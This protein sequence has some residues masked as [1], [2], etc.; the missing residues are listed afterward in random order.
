MISKDEII[1]ILSKY[2]MD[3][4]YQAPYLYEEEGRFGI[5]YSFNHAFY[6][7]LER[8]HWFH[9]VIEAED[10]IYQLWWYKKYRSQFMVSI[11]LEDYE[12]MCPQVF[13]EMNEKELS[14]QDMKNL[15]LDPDEMPKEKKKQNIYRRLL[16]TCRILVAIIE[17]KVK[18]QNDTYGNVKELD[19]EFQRQENEFYQLYNR[20]TKENLALHQILDTVIDKV[21]MDSEIQAL[22]ER[23]DY[24]SQHTS[25][26]DMK[27]FIDSLWDTL[28]SMESEKGYLQN[29][30]LL[31]KLPIDLEDVRKKKEYMES[32]FNKKKSLFSKK[33]H[34]KE[35]LTKIDE[36]SETKK[37]ISMK[38]FIDNEVK[39]LEEK[40][41]II[42]E[43]DYS[44]LG[45]Y[46]NEFDNL[47][48]AAPFELQDKPVEKVYT[49][50]ELLKTYREIYQSLTSEEQRN[51]AIYH[52]FMQPICDAILRQMLEQKMMEEILLRV[53][54]DFEQD[55]TQAMN[56][57]TDSENVFL[58]IQKM[59]SLSL[60]NVNTFL[61]SLYDVCENLLKI[62]AFHL[63][64]IS[65]FFGKSMKNDVIDVYHASL[66][67]VSAPVQ[68]KGSFEVHDI[69]KV[70]SYVSVLFLPYFY[71]IKDSFFH[72]NTIEEIKDRED[73]LIFLKKYQ[74]NF[75]NSDIIKVSRFHAS[76]KFEGPCKIMFGMK[77]LRKEYY[78][79][80]DIIK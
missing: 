43:M 6:G 73:V 29:K 5:L 75:N 4:K 40:Y 53:R 23:I 39:R 45:D 18:V 25:F 10:F 31:F 80:I 33:E 60:K 71:D 36:E 32:V 17:E 51:L 46:L 13:F 62:K 50:D 49:H 24:L 63:N 11:H 55:I 3:S 1:T 27:K 64:G 2:G 44:T 76:E 67:N 30:Y 12:S 28:F 41:S 59:K 77:K 78:R 34:V 26:E 72:D 14:V 15:L 54:R 56:I 48:I 38:D 47:G 66:K 8:V 65:Y 35:T 20:Y 7:L 68:K 52:S 69:L 21:N 57:L 37:I 74:V 58:K 70:H 79:Q 61:K 42:D 9:D 16:R 22:N 19:L